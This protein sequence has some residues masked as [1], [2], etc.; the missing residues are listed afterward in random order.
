MVQA[1]IMAVFVSIFNALRLA[2]HAAGSLES[3]FFVDD[4]LWRDAPL[5]TGQ[6]SFDPLPGVKNIMVT[7]GEGFM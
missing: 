6:T 7:G 4:G 1:G 5:H 2:D 3:R